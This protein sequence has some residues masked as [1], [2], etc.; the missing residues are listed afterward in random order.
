MMNMH[1]VRQRVNLENTMSVC[2]DVSQRKL[3]ILCQVR[4]NGRLLESSGEIPN[5]TA[6]IRVA[7]AKWKGTAAE[8]GCR[9]ILVVCEP[10]GGYEHRLLEIARRMGALTAYVSSEATAKAK[11]ITSNDTGKSDAKDARVI[12]DLVALG[13]TLDH[14]L[15]DDRRRL[16]RELNQMYEAECLAA[17]RCKVEL[18]DVRRHVFPDWSLEARRMYEGVGRAL[19]ECFHCNARRIALCDWPDFKARMLRRNARLKTETLRIVW[20]DA[21]SSS[22]HLGDPELAHLHDA[23]FVE[24][25]E[26]LRTHLER[27]ARC[28]SLMLETYDRL[29]ESDAL[30]ETPV[31]AFAQARIV[32]ETGPL[33]DFSRSSGLMRYA[34]LNICERTS[35]KYIG[36]SKI[37]KRG[38]PLLRKVLYQ[39]VWQSLIGKGKP[40]DEYYRRERKSK[41]HAEV[42]VSLM[43]K[44]LNMLWGVNRSDE[45][46]RLERLFAPAGASVLDD[47]AA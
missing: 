3:T 36:H 43:R 31:P 33:S 5:R 41:S 25:Y 14:R 37:S 42:M 8:H 46:F 21:C 6:D 39:A 18:H 23:R 10:S 4:A 22:L 34:G 9:Q 12:A 20:R 26:D 32:A 45:P 30:A 19:F 29:P 24:L 35:G 2:I 44:A 7:V 17:V 13:R 15:L 11:V 38:R 27:K 47:D 1:Q 28:R 16:L 40:Y